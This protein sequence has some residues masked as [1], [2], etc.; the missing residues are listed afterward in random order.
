M[1]HGDDSVV[2]AVLADYR[3][4]P[5]PEKLRAMLGFLEKLTLN[6]AGIG[7]DDVAPLRAAGL[8]DEKIEDAIHVCA[9]FNVINRVADSLGFDEADVKGYQTGARML[10]NRGYQ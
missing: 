3:T 9:L 7:P 1:A 8:T 2:R 5:I 6:P 4:A 10:L